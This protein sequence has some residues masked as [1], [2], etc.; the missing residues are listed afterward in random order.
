MRKST[1]PEYYTQNYYL[2]TKDNPPKVVN[3][4]IRGLHT[5]QHF[6][7]TLMFYNNTWLDVRTY[8]YNLLSSFVCIA[9]PRSTFISTCFNRAGFEFTRPQ[10][11]FALPYYYHLSFLRCAR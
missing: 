2:P 7:C 5:A 11:V 9:I 8:V 6:E 3:L 1:V 4:G 10:A